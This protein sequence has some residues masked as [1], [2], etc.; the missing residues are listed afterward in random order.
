MPHTKPDEWDAQ[1]KDGAWDYLKSKQQAPHYGV[2]AAYVIEGQG[3]SVLDIGCGI[4]LLST[5]LVEEEYFGI[6]LSEVALQTAADNNM[7]AV[8]EQADA[9]TFEPYGQYDFIIFNESLYYMPDPLYTLSRYKPRK[10]FIISMYG[11]ATRTGKIWAA[12]HE[13]YECTAGVFLRDYWGPKTWTVKRL[14]LKE[15]HPEEMPHH[16]PDA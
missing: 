3:T 1:Y 2:I 15:E 4:G 12:L 5:Y 16:P 14:K 7:F 9:D 6:D 11:G 8:F 10:G 13:K